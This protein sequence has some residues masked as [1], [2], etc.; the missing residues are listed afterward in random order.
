MSAVPIYCFYCGEELISGANWH[1]DH[2]TPRSQGGTNRHDN[3]V[4]ACATCNIQKGDKTIEQY[5]AWVSIAHQRAIN[6]LEACLTDLRR[7]R[8][9]KYL[10]EL[11]TIISREIARCSRIASQEIRF[12]GERLADAVRVAREGILQEQAA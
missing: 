9:G 11:E 1:R 6:V 3:L 7:I 5:R 4:D 12:F 10:M 2:A 8:G